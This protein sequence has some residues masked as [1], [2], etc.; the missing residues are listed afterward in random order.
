MGSGATQDAFCPETAATGG[1]CI[2]D[3]VFL[4]LGKQLAMTA[5]NTGREVKVI[6]LPAEGFVFCAVP[7]LRQ[8]LLMNAAKG[9]TADLALYV[10]QPCISVMQQR[11]AG[12][13]LSV[14]SDE[15]HTLPDEFTVTGAAQYGLIVEVQMEIL[16][17]H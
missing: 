11:H 13:D 17:A 6:K 7:D 9:A 12:T 8:G 1:M 5:I 15:C 4:I 16:L 2:S 10:V 3:A 14:A